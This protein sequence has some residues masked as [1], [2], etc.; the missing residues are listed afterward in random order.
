MC[1]YVI[2]LFRRNESL[3]FH[4]TCSPFQIS[5]AIVIS[6]LEIRPFPELIYEGSSTTLQNIRNMLTKWSTLHNREAIPGNFDLNKQLKSQ[7][8]IGL[9]QFFDKWWIIKTCLGRIWGVI[10]HHC[11]LSCSYGLGH[12]KPI[13]TDCIMMKWLWPIRLGSLNCLIDV[14]RGGIKK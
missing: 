7:E 8:T 1:D 9:V 3:F 6:F 10:W 2:S 5:L 13:V 14:W 4:G 12:Y 11:K